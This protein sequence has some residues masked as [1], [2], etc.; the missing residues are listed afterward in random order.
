M[1]ELEKQAIIRS[2]VRTGKTD[3][4]LCKLLQAFGYPVKMDMGLVEVGDGKY[5]AMPTMVYGEK[6]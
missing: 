6:K 1:T 3:V 5:V 2:G 4:A